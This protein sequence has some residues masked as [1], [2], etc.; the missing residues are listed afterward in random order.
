MFLLVGGP[1]GGF[2]ALSAAGTGAF[3]VR[4]RRRE[5]LPEAPLH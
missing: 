3:F 5:D 4:K 1:L 2:L